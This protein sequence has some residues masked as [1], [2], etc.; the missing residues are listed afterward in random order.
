MNPIVQSLGTVQAMRHED[1][2]IDLNG[3][4]QQTTVD[5]IPVVAASS[6][7]FVDPRDV[8]TKVLGHCVCF[9]LSREEQRDQYSDLVARLATELNLERLFE[10]RSMLNTGALIVYIAYLEY[11]KIA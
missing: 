1:V 8:P 5:N 9:D 6:S 11:I 2:Q 3:K 7:D 4:T 10:E